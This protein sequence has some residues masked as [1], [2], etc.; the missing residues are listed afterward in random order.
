MSNSAVNSA[1]APDYLTAISYHN[2]GYAKGIKNSTLT[3]TG[4]K[5]F[6]NNSPCYIKIHYLNPHK[7]IA[8]CIEHLCTLFW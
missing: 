3:T 1:K 2:F 4:N 7:I 6:V 8:Y 5:T